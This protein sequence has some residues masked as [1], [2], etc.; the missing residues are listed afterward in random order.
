MLSRY[1][2]KT[3]VQ[4]V[5]NSTDKRNKI[6]IIKEKSYIMKPGSSKEENS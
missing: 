3:Y 4:K 6:K 1:T 2:N 5:F